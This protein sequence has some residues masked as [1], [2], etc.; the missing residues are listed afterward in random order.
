MIQP[1]R[2]VHRR[3]FVLLALVLP[4][5]FIAGLLARRPLVPAERVSDRISLVLPSGA[6]MVIDSRDLWGSAVDAPDPLVYWTLAAPAPGSLPGGARLLGSLEAAR[7]NRLRLPGDTGA[8]GYLILYSLAWH[9]P[10]AQAPVPKE[11]P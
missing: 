7:R 2:K 5:V 6:E 8:R 3:S 1:L 11:M 10:V 4:A 9:K